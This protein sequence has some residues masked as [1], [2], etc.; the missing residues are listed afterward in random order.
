MCKKALPQWERHVIRTNYTINYNVEHEAHVPVDCGRILQHDGVLIS[1]LDIDGDTS[2][3]PCL[4]GGL[5]F[6]RSDVPD[7]L[8]G[9]PP[10]PPPPPEPRPKT[11]T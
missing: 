11:S 10:P 1:L 7:R 5:V 9:P 8:G 4:D 6:D 2:S 3:N